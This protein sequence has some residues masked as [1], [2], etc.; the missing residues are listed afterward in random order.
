MECRAIALAKD[1]KISDYV[2]LPNPA[3]R[4]I[5]ILLQALDVVNQAGLDGKKLTDIK[6]ITN[7]SPSSLDTYYEVHAKVT[8]RFKEPTK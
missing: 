5:H 8:H 7:R 6:L 2:H 4:A 1:R 3:E